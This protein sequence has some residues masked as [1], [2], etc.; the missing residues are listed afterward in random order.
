MTC[1]RIIIVGE[2]N[3]MHSKGGRS[4]YNVENN[5]LLETVSIRYYNV[6]FFLTYDKKKDAFKMEK[7]IERVNA[8]E[9]MTM[10]SLANWCRSQQIYFTTQFIYRK[11]F[12]IKANI[13]NFYPYCRFKREIA[14]SRCQTVHT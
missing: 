8:G 3:V 4:V 7:L 10:K 14:K 5:S 12:P 1:I 11:D 13:W 9:Q 2:W 6:L